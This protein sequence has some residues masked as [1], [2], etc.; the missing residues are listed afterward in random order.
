MDISTLLNNVNQYI[1]NPIIVLLFV[2]AFLYFLVGIVKLIA[3]AGNEKV[4]ETGKQNMLWGLVGMFIMFGVFGIIN[5]ILKTF[6]ITGPEYL[7]GSLNLLRI[8]LG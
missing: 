3:G 6:G 1:L 4:R 2:L 5:I 8:Y 7:E